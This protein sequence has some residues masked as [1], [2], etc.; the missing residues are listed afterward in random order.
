MMQREIAKAIGVDTSTVSQWMVRL[1]IE[2]RSKG[3]G[4]IAEAAL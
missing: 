4:S 2:A 3:A 1:G